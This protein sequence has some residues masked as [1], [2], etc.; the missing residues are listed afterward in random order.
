MK[1]LIVDDD[2]DTIGIV[3]AFLKMAFP[4]IIIE[5]ARNGM[6]AIEMVILNEN[7]FDA[8]ITDLSMPIING[9]EMCRKLKSEGNSAVFIL[10]T[11]HH[12][13]DEDATTFNMIFDKPP[14]MDEL[15]SYLR[16][17]IGS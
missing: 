8:I 6:A 5:I 9:R 17:M 1:V 2:P 4:N 15:V 3:S 11:G 16:K 12:P 13:T 10:L 14:N 7:P